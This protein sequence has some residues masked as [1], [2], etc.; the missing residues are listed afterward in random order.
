M[1][2]RRAKA[3]AGFTII[4][5]MITVT[6][7][8][9]L[10]AAAMPTMRVW[11]VNNKVR[12]VTDALQT[13]L[14]LAQSES[15]RRSRLVVFALTNTNTPTAIPL[16]AAADATAWAIYTV[17]SMT[18]GTETPEFIQSGVLSNASAGVQVISNG[19]AAVCFNS[20]GRLVNSAGANITAITGGATCTQ[21]GGAPAVQKFNISAPGGDRPLQVNLGLGG[22]IHM[23]DF[24]VAISDAHPEG[25]P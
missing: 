17:P 13:G 24:N 7:F 15:L 5:M 20:V 1:L 3:D 22:Q 9:I 2:I 8:A 11:I 14:R 16:G 12:A 23:C 19:A 6:V 10:A 4:E 25:C 21:P 18:D